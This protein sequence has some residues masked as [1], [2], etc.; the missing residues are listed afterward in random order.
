M[1]RRPRRLESILTAAGLAAAATAAAIEVEIVSPPAGEAVFGPV[2]IVAE[3][4]SGEPV[5]RVELFLDGRS[6]GAVSEPPYRLLVDVGQENREHRIEAVAHGRDGASARAERTTPAIHI[7]DEVGLELQQLYATVTRGR[8]RR[9][10][11]LDQR[12]FRIR[13]DGRPQ[14]IVTF[15]RGDIPFTA[16]LLIDG[17]SSMLG[18]RF[19]AA[20][21]GAREFVDGMRRHDE[22]RLMVFG[23]RL[24][25]VTPFAGSE[26]PPSPDAGADEA[27]GG[28]S[29]YDHLYLALAALEERQGRRVVVLLS[30]GVDLHSVLSPGELRDYARRSRAM[31]YWVRPQGEGSEPR[32]RDLRELRWRTAQMRSRRPRSVSWRPPLSSWRDAEAV[33]EGVS[34]LE[35]IVEETGGRA[36]EVASVDDVGPAFAEILAELREQY[37]LGYYPDPRRN[38][39]SWR[40]VDVDVAGGRYQVR[41][42]AGYVDR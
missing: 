11:D 28:T 12:H 25:Q 19:D 21:A 39:G 18:E 2:E 33:T 6:V 14:E 34:T 32:D 15:G 20:L 24:Y 31:I 37:A 35:Q 3:V 1:K 41:T 9:A 23:D 26:A 29:I 30:D 38:D 7:D 40:K 27:M 16:A 17:S 5:E 10:L 42:R 36:L 22:A 13:D 4:R 8:R